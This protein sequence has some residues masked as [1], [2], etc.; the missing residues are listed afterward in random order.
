MITVSLHKPIVI[1]TRE[2]D[3]AMQEILEAFMPRDHTFHVHCFTSGRPFGNWVLKT[4]PNAY[5]GITGVVS[6]N[7]PHVQ[8]FIKSGEL[9]LERMLMET[10][11]PFMT[12]K[13]IYRW[14]KKTRPG[15][16][17]KKRF[18]ISHSG[19]IP[20]TA[21][22]VAEWVS[23]GRVTRGEKGPVDVEEVLKVTA[24]NACKVYGIVI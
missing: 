17:G 10:D 22:L 16:E 13:N 21:E 6:Y 2:A 15:A 11:S 12:P 8:N 7:L 14:L 3:E 24:A 20:F 4:F 5:I 9:P 18:E 23:E 1:H 19:M